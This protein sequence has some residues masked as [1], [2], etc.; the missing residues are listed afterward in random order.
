MLGGSQHRGGVI[1]GMAHFALSSGVVHEVEIADE[2]AVVE[3]GTVGRGPPAAD[4]RAKRRPAEIVDKG[5][6]SPDRAGSQRS[7]GAS[8][9]IE[10]AALQAVTRLGRHGGAVHAMSEAGDTLDGVAVWHTIA[11]PIGRPTPRIRIW[12]TATLALVF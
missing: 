2:A 12:I 11:L 5:A 10:Q 7:D 3:A 4:Q 8:E 6:N 9:C 1:G